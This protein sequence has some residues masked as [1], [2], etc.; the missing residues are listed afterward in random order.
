MGVLLFLGVVLGVT[1]E[2]VPTE[3]NS[4]RGI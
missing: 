4:R 2:A 3:L 1:V